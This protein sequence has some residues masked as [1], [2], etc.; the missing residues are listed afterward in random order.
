MNSDIPGA[1]VICHLTTTSLPGNQTLTGRSCA[2][3]SSKLTRLADRISYSPAPEILQYFINVAHK[4]H[5]YKYIKLSHVVTAANWNGDEGK[6]F[7]E[8]KNLTTGEIIK[9]WG[10]FL[11]NGSGILK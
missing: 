4:Y 5:L 10:H 6:W 11:I 1:L 7:V 2:C 3:L 9:D 8:I